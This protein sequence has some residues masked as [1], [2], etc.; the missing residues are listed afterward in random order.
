MRFQY[1]LSSLDP[2]KL[3]AAAKLLKA[4]GAQSED[5]L[6]MLWESP[7]QI[8]KLEKYEVRA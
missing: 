7:K 1:D 5:E 6:L 8:T 4:A 2:I 3:P